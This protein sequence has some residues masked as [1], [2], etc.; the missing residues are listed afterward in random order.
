MA[1]ED[2]NQAARP[3][4]SPEQRAAAQASEQPAA[5]HNGQ[6][7]GV[8][9]STD[10][11]AEGQTPEVDGQAERQ[12]RGAEGQADREPLGNALSDQ[13]SSRSEGSELQ[14]AWDVWQAFRDLLPL[15]RCWWVKLHFR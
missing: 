8:S 6:H 14:A 15:E 11:H 5:A 7:Q 3:A 2:N 10:R 1:G 12:P 9:S 13:Q 4:C